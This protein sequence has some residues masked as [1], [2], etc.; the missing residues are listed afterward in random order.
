MTLRNRTSHR[1]T[2]AEIAWQPHTSSFT[3]S[4]RCLFSSQLSPSTKG[5]AFPRRETAAVTCG[6]PYGSRQPRRLREGSAPSRL[7]RRTI[8]AADRRLGPAAAQDPRSPR[9]P[10]PAPVARPHRRP[11]P[12]ESHLVVEIQHGSHGPTEP[13]RPLRALPTP[14]HE[15]K[16]RAG[17][18][19][20]GSP[21]PGALVNWG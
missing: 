15:P 13:R 20:L 11:R 7:A 14:P 21:R 8:A 1:G 12:R 10:R 19:G 5:C 16:P 2:R 6:L 3:S 17:A 9:S 4:D 18:E